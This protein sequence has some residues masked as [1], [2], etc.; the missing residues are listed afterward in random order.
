MRTPYHTLVE[1]GDDGRWH[2]VF[3]DYDKAVV[4][5]ERDAIGRDGGVVM[6]I[7]TTGD[8][9]ADIDAAVRELNAAA[10]DARTA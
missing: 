8:A 9:Q 3:G 10:S 1:R 4:R 5:E 2:V 7:I 6:K